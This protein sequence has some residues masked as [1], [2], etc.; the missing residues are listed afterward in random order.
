MTTTYRAAYWIS[1]DR[2]GEIVLTTA[3]Q[4]S[5][6]DDDLLASAR[7]EAQA[8]APWALESGEIRIGD[9]TEV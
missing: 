5:L 9:W 7:A 6:P 3:E 8:H 4:A 1:D 2:Q